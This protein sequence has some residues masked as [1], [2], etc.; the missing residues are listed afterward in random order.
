[1]D[2]L[3]DKV[4]SQVGEVAKSSQKVCSICFF[5]HEM[6]SVKQKCLRTVTGPAV[7]IDKQLGMRALYVARLCNTPADFTDMRVESSFYISLFTSPLM[8][9]CI[10][11]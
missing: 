1:M 6:L 11:W 4:L 9:L 7:L 3:M 8:C 10:G 2:I 5:T